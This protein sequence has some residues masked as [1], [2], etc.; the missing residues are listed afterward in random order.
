MNKTGLLV[1]A[2]FVAG[3]GVSIFQLFDRPNPSVNSMT[4]PDLSGIE[5]GDAIAQVALPAS[6]SEQAKLG[7][8][9][10][11]AKCADCHGTNAA[12]QKGIAPPLVHRIYEPSHHSDLAFV[13]AARNGVQSHHW[14]FGNMPR[15]EGI[16][17]GE[18]K[19]VATYVRELQRENGIF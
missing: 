1:G 14:D 4:P 2:V 6:L 7:K 15:I 13:A 16:T 3:V 17:D 5:D 10:F 8:R 12:G 9:I 19:L 18:V 11:E